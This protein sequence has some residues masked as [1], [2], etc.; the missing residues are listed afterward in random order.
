MRFGIRN[1][2]A[3]I[4]MNIWWAEEW[5]RPDSP[6]KVRTLNE[7]ERNKANELLMHLAGSG[8]EPVNDFETPAIAIY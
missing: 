2:P 5:L 6:Y 3:Y 4:R 7:E 1:V 8:A